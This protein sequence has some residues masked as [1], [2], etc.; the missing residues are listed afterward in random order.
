MRDS[1]I[2]PEK[3]ANLFTIFKMVFGAFN[4]SLN[5][6][7]ATLAGNAFMIV[8]VYIFNFMLMSLLVAIFINRYRQV[9]SNIDAIRRMEFIN[10]KNTK[11]DDPIIGAVT[12][13]FFPIN[14][15]L[16]PFI[17]PVVVFKSYRVNDFILKIQYFTLVLIYASLGLMLA[18]VVI[19]LLIL[20]SL[21]NN[22]YLAVIG[23]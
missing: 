6:N 21:A 10:L 12:M 17:I 7:G 9:W 13:T 18:M 23:C 1:F 19:P 22:F 16:L 4:S 20:K 11:S 5:F 3:E 15:I 14:V 2:K 8:E